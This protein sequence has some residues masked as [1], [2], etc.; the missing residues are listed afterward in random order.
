MKK[1][2]NN[3][4]HLRRSDDFP[5]LVVSQDYELFFQRSGSIEKCLVEPSENLVRFAEK[6]GIKITFFVDAGMICR[7]QELSSTSPTLQKELSQVKVHVESLAS[8]GHE[9][10]LHVHP[11]WEDTR[12]LGDRWDFAGSRYQLRDFT[13]EEISDIFSRYTRALNDLCDGA[14][15]T[16][17]AGGFCVEPF[18]RISAALRNEGIWVDSSVVPGALLKDPEKGFNFS[19]VPDLPFWSFDE[20]PLT[21]VGNGSFL[22]VAITPQVL[23]FFHYWGRA[24]DRML[25]RQPASVIGDGSSK[26]IG[27]YEVLRRLS[28]SGRTSELSID[29]PKAGGLTSGK[30]TRQKRQI[31]QIM[32]H[33][34]LL[35]RP[36]F[37]ALELFLELNR[38]TRF[39]TVGGLAQLIRMD[40]PSKH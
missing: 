35:G 12:R 30:L 24:W 25:K 36:S 29:A 11:H 31:W 6:R 32:G 28:G 27:R 23:P 14:V 15:S 40:G 1:I 26:A 4:I 19:Q 18:Q 13:D 9:I 22:E 3:D 37:E 20:S 10:G 39:E 2:R 17:R 16:Y 38:I 33:P 8:K 34:K 5:V 21:Q 7:M